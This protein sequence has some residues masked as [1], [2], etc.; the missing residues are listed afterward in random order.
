MRVMH[1]PKPVRS[2]ESRE[3]KRL[4]DIRQA[5]GSTDAH[6]A[7]K[8]HSCRLCQPTA[9]Q[10]SVSQSIEAAKAVITLLQSRQRCAPSNWRKKM[11]CT[12]RVVTT[13][14]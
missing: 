9:V 7:I 6:L 1:R 5:S 12:N 4:G 14:R 3:P 2:P 11:A 10:R 13:R 8:R